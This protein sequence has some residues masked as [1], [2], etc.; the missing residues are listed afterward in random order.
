VLVDDVE[1]WVGDPAR[2][3]D[4]PVFDAPVSLGLHLVEVEVAAEETFVDSRTPATRVVRRTAAVEV[5]GD[6]VAELAIEARGATSGYDLR[7]DFR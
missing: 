1:V 4:G 6:A 3:G 7:F 2:L 5:T